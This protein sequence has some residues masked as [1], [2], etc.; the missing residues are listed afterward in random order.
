MKAVFFI[1]KEKFGGAKNKLYA[2]ELVSKQSI[3]VKDSGAL[4]KDT[5]GYYIQIDG[6]EEAIKKAKELLKELAKEVEGGEADGINNAI[7]EQESSAADGF[8]AIF[9]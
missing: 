1:E 8:G 2:D 7:D 6:D 4:G 5:D 3:T 9:G